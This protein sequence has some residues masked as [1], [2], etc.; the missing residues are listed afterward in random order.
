MTYVLG[1]YSDAYQQPKNEIVVILDAGHGGKDGGASSESGIQERDLVFA[2]TKKVE[3]YL[4][5]QG[6]KVKL[7][8]EDEADLA[9]EEARNRKAEDLKN[10]IDLI[11]ETEQAILVSIH[12]NATTN[13]SWSGAQT[14]YD[15]KKDENEQLA[16]CIMNSFQKNLEMTRSPQATSQLY[17]LKH[18]EVPATL[19][20]I[21][22]LSNAEEAAKLGD[23]A[24]QEQVAY[25]I[26]EGVSAYIDGL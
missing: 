16:I 26:Y 13:N 7:T 25:A 20:E 10:R 12:A 6:I 1:E 14:F 9:S 4:R 17:L 22:F 5:G 19:V 23:E 8:R 18:S 2:I 11:N 21:G 15:P 3:S 24:Y